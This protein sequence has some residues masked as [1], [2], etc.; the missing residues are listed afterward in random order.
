MSDIN[1]VPGRCFGGYLIRD[2][3][4]AKTYAGSGRVCFG[5]SLHSAGGGNVRDYGSRTIDD[6]ICLA[7]K[8][9]AKRQE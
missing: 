7:G 9:L 2:G 4:G 5:F 1:K 6:W 3:T 8:I